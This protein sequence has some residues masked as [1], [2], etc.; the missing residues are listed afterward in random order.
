M[1]SIESKIITYTPIGIL[2]SNLQRPY[3]APRQGVLNQTQEAVVLLY[4][5]IPTDALDDLAGFDR[6]W[7]LYDFNRNKSWKP[8]FDHHEEVR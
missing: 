2:R 3:E 6:V 7:L 8:K 5:H 1:L 4:D